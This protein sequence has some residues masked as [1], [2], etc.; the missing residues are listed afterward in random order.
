MEEDLERLKQMQNNLT[1]ASGSLSSTQTNATSKAIDEIQKKL[2]WF[3]KNEY[4][5]QI[6]AKN[7]I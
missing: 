4:K 3:S 5:F 1:Q 2:D 7:Y 6:H